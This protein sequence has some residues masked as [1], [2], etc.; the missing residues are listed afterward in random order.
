MN[1][2]T[3]KGTIDAAQDFSESWLTLREPADHDARNL[4]L[5]DQLANWAASFDTLNI[6]ELGAG[7]GSNLR[8]LMPRLGHQ[9]HWV[10]IDNDA[11]LLDHLPRIL[12]PWAE[13]NGARVKTGNDEFLIEHES[14]SATVKSQVVNLAS[15]LDQLP[16]HN[17]NLLT[18]SALLDLTSESW[19]DRLAM[20]CEN[21]ACA[22]LFA[23]NYNGKIQWQPELDT[24][25]KVTE[26]L[27][28]HQLHDKGFGNALGPVA[29]HHFAKTLNLLGRQVET[30][31]SDW[32]VN[33]QSP[34]LQHAIID[35]WAPAAME[36]DD[37]ARK[38]IDQ[39]R[40]TR[41]KFIEK[42]VSGLT[43]GHV[44]VLSLP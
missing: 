30:G 28:R 21:H 4:T 29:G 34:A 10:L 42:G 1:E 5:T 43:V 25:F 14:F 15:Q 6:V 19:L 31:D 35:G 23:L 18:A 27:N 12:Q 26:L 20:L 16:M 8:Y 7:T 24:D 39:W 22:C 37:T 13:K 32:A 44:D 17:V 9:Q 11:A 36:Q 38:M 33:N 41:S 3:N 40:S 2:D